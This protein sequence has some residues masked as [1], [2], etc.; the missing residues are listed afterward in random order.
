[1][2]I[3]KWYC[4][5]FNRFY[6]TRTVNFSIKKWTRIISSAINVQYRTKIL[7]CYNLLALS[8]S[9]LSDSVVKL[10]IW[11]IRSYLIWEWGEWIQSCTISYI[12]TMITNCFALNINVM[13]VITLCIS[14]IFRCNSTWGHFI[15]LLLCLLCI[16]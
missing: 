10:L 5:E 1:M 16:Q 15:L 4:K 14:T 3:N 8:S 11:H 6:F 2:K 13:L 9:W 12:H 7:C